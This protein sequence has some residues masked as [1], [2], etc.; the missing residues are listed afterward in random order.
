MTLKTENSCHESEERSTAYVMLAVSDTGIG[1]S[2]GVLERA[3]EPLFTT[4]PHGKGSGFGLSMVYGLVS[5]AGGHISIDSEVGQ[6]TTIRLYLPPAAVASVPSENITREGV[7][8]RKD[9]R[10]V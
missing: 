2:A 5:Q 8:H 9:Q 1:M 4:K 6:G 10:M 7:A 3:F